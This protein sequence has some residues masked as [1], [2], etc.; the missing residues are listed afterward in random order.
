MV[1][2]SL[3]VATLVLLEAVDVVAALEVIAGD[4]AVEVTLVSRVDGVKVPELAVVVWLTVV[5][6]SKNI[7]LSKNTNEFFSF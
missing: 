2:C 1:G 3:V 5:V 7:G 6:T 4:V